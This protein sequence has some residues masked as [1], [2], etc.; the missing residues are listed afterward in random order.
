MC[1]K[2]S[3]RDRYR[4]RGGIVVEGRLQECLRGDVLVEVCFGNNNQIENPRYRVIQVSE[5]CDT[6]YSGQNTCSSALL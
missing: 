4:T 1:T 3:C 6:T 2:R 5:S